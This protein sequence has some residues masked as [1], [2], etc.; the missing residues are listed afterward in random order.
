MYHVSEQTMFHHIRSPR[1]KKIMLLTD[2]Q[3]HAI[4]SSPL[5]LE[6]AWLDYG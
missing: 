6:S 5:S 2:K 1:D 3:E 4:V